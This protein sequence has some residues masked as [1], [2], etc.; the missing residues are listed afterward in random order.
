MAALDYSR[1]ELEKFCK[2]DKYMEAF[3]KEVER[4]NDDAEFRESLSE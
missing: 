3:K 2:G 4:L 1:Q